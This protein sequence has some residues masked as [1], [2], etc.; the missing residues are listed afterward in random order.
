MI[1]LRYLKVA[2][3]CTNPLVLKM[4]PINRF[5][6]H[7][8]IILST[9]EV[10]QIAHIQYLFYLVF[11]SQ[12]ALSLDDSLCGG[13]LIKPSIILTAS[14]CLDGYYRLNRYFISIIPIR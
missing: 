1:P 12:A 9:R 6:P 3:S 7:L 4:R 2:L 5:Q 10:A 11:S 14:H 8:R 13:T